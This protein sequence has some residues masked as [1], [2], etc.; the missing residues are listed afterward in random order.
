MLAIFRTRPANHLAILETQI[1]LRDLL[2][3]DFTF[4]F[5]ERGLCRLVLKIG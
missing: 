2:A 4:G 3:A 1:A 5:V